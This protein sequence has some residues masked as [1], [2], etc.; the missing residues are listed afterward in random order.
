MLRSSLGLVALIALST[1]S[2]AGKDSNKLAAAAITAGAAV[3]VAAAHV[4]AT[5]GCWGDCPTGTRC[6]HDSNTCVALPCRGSCPAMMRCERVGG[7]ETCVAGVADTAEAPTAT[8]SVRPPSDGDPC[9]GLCF[10]GERCKI[11]DGVADCV[12]P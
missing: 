12:R 3:A 7:E 2:C 4:A 6:D 11:T 9:K 8:P 5:D 1:C 10:A